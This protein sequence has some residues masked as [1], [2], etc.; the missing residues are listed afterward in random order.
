MRPDVSNHVARTFSAAVTPT[1]ERHVKETINKSLIPAYTQATGQMQQ[2]MARDFHAE[3]LNL[4]KEVVTWQ[5][6]ALKGTEVC[7]SLQ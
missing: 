6:E 2:E 1:V 7:S 4:R 5:S 3:I